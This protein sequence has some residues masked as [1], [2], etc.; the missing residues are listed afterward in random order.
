MATVDDVPRRI[1]GER[2]TLLGW[3][4][5]ILLQLAHPLVAAGVYHHS[6]FRD[7]AAAAIGRLHATTRAMLSLVFGTASERLQAVDH[8]LA[9]H[10]RVRGRLETPVGPFPAGTTYSAEDPAL[11]LWVH[12][13]LVEC[14]VGT[15]ELFV[16]GLT[17]AERDAYCDASA[18]IA[19]ALG[20]PGTD[21]PR[22]WA[23]LTAANRAMLRSGVLTVSAEARELARAL[24]YGPTMRLVPPAAWASRL[25]TTGLL[26]SEL[27]DAYGLAWSPARERR[28][29]RLSRL[30][31]SVRRLAPAPV[32]RFAAARRACQND[33]P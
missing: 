5:A 22:K 25:V 24:L 3:P 14:S 31:R 12:T 8:I 23:I 13:S 17:E 32:A 30:T 1:N 28:F 4:A 9:V 2:L 33:C 6:G 20:A 10:R 7:S 26:P 15:Y 18:A 27:R 19:V 11:V 29:R 21:V 16:A